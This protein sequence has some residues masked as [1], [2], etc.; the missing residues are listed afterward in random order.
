VFTEEKAIV[1]MT[2]IESKAFQPEPTTVSSTPPLTPSAD[3]NIDTA[4]LDTAISRATE[5][6]IAKQAPGGWWVG[7]LQ[8]DSIL[9][10]EYILLKWILSQETDPD[11]IKVANYLR[12]LQ[13]PDGGW[14]QYPGGPPDISGCVKAYFALKLMGDDPN[15]PH[16]KKARDLILRIGGAEK[17]NTFSRFYYACLGQISFDSC[18]SIPPE[19][20]FLPKWV[21]FNLYNVS[22]WTRTMILPLGIVTTLRPVREI[23]PHLGIK[24]LY[25]DYEAGNTLGIPEPGFPKTWRD[26][27]LRL[28]RVLKR[29]EESPMQTLRE[30]AMSAAEKWL[31]E[32]MVNSEGLGAIF[33]PMVY[34]LIVLKALGYAD[35]HPMVLKGH[36]E[37]KDFYI[38][39]GDTIRLQPCVSPVWDTGIALHA[40]AETG[41]NS[42]SES[43]QRGTQWLLDKE[44]RFASDWQK[45]VRKIE[46]SGWYFEFCNPH[47][48]DTDDTAMAVMSLK[49]LGGEKA[50]AAIARGVQF[51][52]AFQNSDGGWAA[53]DKT[54]SRPILEAIPFADHNAMQDPSCPDITGR[55]LESLGHNG[56]TVQDRLVR[57]AIRFIRSQQDACGAWW[58]RW[59]VNFI[60]GT[61]Q[62]LEGLA[63]VGE[64]MDS[65][66]I[67]KAVA[68]LKSVQK[69]DGSFGESCAS[70]DDPAQ[71][72]IGESTASQTAW[73]VMGIMAGAG[74]NDPAVKKGIDW[75]IAQQADHGGWD[76]EPFTGTG[77]PKV[78]YMRYHLYRHYFPLMALGRYRGKRGIQNAE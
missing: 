38:E 56:L 21:Y 34:M 75:L 68:W 6:L 15:A 52:L 2:S 40:L 59:G 19:V 67:Q 60:Y 12:Q 66:Y 13:N 4:N 17:S 36:K 32:R 47:Y 51:L 39:E 9:E 28:D 50:R 31:T 70:Y 5:S 20:V 35:D 49:R 30:R 45:K 14:S 24:E 74:A 69:P 63:S 71:K 72:G 1:S 64:S 44:V 8:G 26:F 65:I 7:E 29:Y 73:G 18:P 57:R 23:P 53:F 10:S 46:P 27:F 11:L 25:L 16:M 78:F 37:L 62:V 77:F 61:W 42:D 41:L 55:I 76:E 3:D 48:P 58:G 33:P 43:A 22:A 54:E